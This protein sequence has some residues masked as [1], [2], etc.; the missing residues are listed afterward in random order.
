MNTTT[1]VLASDVDKLY[2]LFSEVKND[3]VILN[4]T[5][6]GLKNY[7]QA[8]EDQLTTGYKLFFNNFIFN[9]KN[10]LYCMFYMIQKERTLSTLYFKFAVTY[11][12]IF[13]NHAVC[14]MS[15]KISKAESDQSLDV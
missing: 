1:T 13:I 3:W 6:V 4:A 5:V 10:I 12:V 15:Q 14:V 9:H 2:T 8:K 7:F 11:W